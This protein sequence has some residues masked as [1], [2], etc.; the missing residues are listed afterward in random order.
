MNVSIELFAMKCVIT[1]AGCN[2]GFLVGENSVK[3]EA[4]ALKAV[5]ELGYES[6]QAAAEDNVFCAVE[7]DDIDDMV[8]ASINGGE[9]IMLD[10]LHIDRLELDR[11]LKELIF[12]NS[13]AIAA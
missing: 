13:S 1:G 6:F 2:K 11:A 3:S 9:L 10:D 8:Y 5:E 12:Y 7:Y 4:H